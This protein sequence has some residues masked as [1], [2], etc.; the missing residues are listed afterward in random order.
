MSIIAGRSYAF[1]VGTA[2]GVN[3]G[4]NGPYSVGGSFDGYSGGDALRA[5]GADGFEQGWDLGFRVDTE[6]GVFGL[7]FSNLI[8]LV[9]FRREGP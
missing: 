3:I 5:D 6:I 8:G 4:F 7:S 2:V 1:V 9:P